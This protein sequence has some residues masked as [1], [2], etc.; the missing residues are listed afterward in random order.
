MSLLLNQKSFVV[1]LHLLFE[2]LKNITKPKYIQI[3]STDCTISLDMLKKYISEGYKILYEYIDDLSP[4]LV[5]TNELPKNIKVQNI[6][7]RK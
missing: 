4:A 3:Y 6:L 5:G 2:E 1:L 7:T